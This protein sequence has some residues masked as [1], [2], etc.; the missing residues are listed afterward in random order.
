MRWDWLEW[1]DWRLHQRLDCSKL[2]YSLNCIRD[3]LCWDWEYMKL[4][5]MRLHWNAKREN[6][7][8]DEIDY[9]SDVIGDCI[10]DST[11]VK[12]TTGYIALEIISTEIDNK[13][14]QIRWDWIKWEI[15][16]WEENA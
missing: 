1:R 7:G 16:E 13:W 3:N 14:K 11:K 12:W 8:W 10:R 6:S 2:D 4:D 9:Q 5:E 15:T